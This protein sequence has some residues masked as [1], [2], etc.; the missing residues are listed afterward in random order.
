MPASAAAVAQ[1]LYV[2]MAY[3]LVDY[4]S[5][6]AGR[7]DEGRGCALEGVASES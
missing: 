6:A 1:E 2:A 3:Q 5:D 7:L 4:V